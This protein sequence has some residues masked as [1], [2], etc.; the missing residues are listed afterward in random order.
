V[1][2]VIF[3]TDAICKKI[4]KSFLKISCKFFGYQHLLHFKNHTMLKD[5]TIFIPEISQLN[6]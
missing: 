2:K 6:N 5:W 1:K 3:Q 4:S